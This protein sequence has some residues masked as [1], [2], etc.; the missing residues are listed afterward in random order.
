MRVVPEPWEICR[1]RENALTRLGVN[2]Q[3]VGVAMSIT[4]LLGI[5]DLLQGAI[6]LG[7]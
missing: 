6:P 1:Q 7:F 4:G 2:G 3:A 5:N